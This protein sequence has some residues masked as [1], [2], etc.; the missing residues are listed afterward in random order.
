MVGLFLQIIL[1]NK[2]LVRS[3]FVVFRVQS[4]KFFVSKDGL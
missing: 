2:P 3:N 4:P 1:Q